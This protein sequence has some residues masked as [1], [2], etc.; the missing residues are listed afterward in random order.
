MDNSRVFNFIGALWL[1]DLYTTF[2]SGEFDIF[3]GVGLAVQFIIAMGIILA[4][5]SIVLT[6]QG[7]ANSFK[8]GDAKEINRKLDSIMAL[9]QDMKGIQPQQPRQ[10]EPLPQKP[11]IPSTVDYGDSGNA[12]H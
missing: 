4:P 1:F 10:A 9:L 7:I 5:T 8:G 11:F 3:E 6:L 2:S 12:D